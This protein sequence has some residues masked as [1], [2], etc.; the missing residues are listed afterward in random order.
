MAGPYLGVEALLTRDELDGKCMGIHKLRM[1]SKC[2]VPL[3]VDGLGL[4]GV[5]GVCSG[6]G[7]GR[8]VD[9]PV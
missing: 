8:Q 6:R 1:S 2:A 3:Y 5:I 9:K 7:G 4:H